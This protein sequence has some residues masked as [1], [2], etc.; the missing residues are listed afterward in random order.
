MPTAFIIGVPCAGACN[1]DG[2]SRSCQQVVL[3]SNTNWT[4]WRVRVRLRHLRPR[5]SDGS[6]RSF[7]DP[8][9]LGDRAVA[10][11]CDDHRLTALADRRR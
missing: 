4:E 3:C 7:F 1:V 9:L 11:V 8:A 5:L 10:C 6:E 2:G